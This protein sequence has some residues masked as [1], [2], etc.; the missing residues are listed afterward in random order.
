[1]IEIVLFGTFLWGLIMTALHGEE[2]KKRRDCHTDLA[3]LLHDE[4]IDESDLRRSG[5]HTE[6]QRWFDE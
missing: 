1:M 5:D 3:Q 6:L 2:R 4:K